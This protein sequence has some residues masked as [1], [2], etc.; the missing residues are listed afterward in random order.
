MKLRA[1]LV[2]LLVTFL[3]SL[4]NAQDGRQFLDDAPFLL[5]F[6]QSEVLDLW[7]ERVGLG[8][9]SKEVTVVK[10]RDEAGAVRIQRFDA[11]GKEIKSDEPKDAEEV[12]EN[13]I[14]PRVFE[15][16]DRKFEKDEPLR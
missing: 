12:S 13:K 10:H 14:S 11:E 8:E 15:L 16:F 7:T 2:I 6:E 1:S 4:T 5:Q 9:N 3:S